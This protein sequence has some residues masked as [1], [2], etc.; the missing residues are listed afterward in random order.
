VKT[1]ALFAFFILL[2]FPALSQTIDSTAIRQVD[3]LIKV[4]RDLTG[5]S[6]FDKA[7][8]A[9][10]AAEKIA[11]EKLGRESAAYGT[12]CFN[13]GRVKYFSGNYQEAEKWYIESRNI[14]EK[15]L[16]SEHPDYALSLKNL[17]GTY[18]NMGPGLEN[19]LRKP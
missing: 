1:S 19:R 15:T 16:G 9:S 2:S 4:S 10:A 11:L 6:D 8:E 14:R 13:Q 18:F 3:S 5:E 17:A 12:C 7:L